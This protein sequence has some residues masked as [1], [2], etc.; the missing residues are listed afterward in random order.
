MFMAFMDFDGFMAKRL[1]FY[2]NMLWLN[3]S[4]MLYYSSAGYIF[5]SRALV[6]YICQ[7]AITL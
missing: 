6:D 4:I 3:D 2:F 7:F 5:I 1:S